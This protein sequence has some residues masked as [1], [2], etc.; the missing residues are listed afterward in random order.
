MAD[1]GVLWLIIFT[2]IIGGYFLPT[3]IALIRHTDK[4]A[5]IFLINLIGSPLLI[6][7]PAAMILA[8]GPR[9]RA[10]QRSRPGR[11][12]SVPGVQPP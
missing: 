7:W 1:S 12:D 10:R 11:W 3:L 4:L 8:F 5:L 9:R 6:G 2:V